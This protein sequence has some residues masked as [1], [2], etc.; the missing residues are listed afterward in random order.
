MYVLIVNIM[1]ASGHAIKT[2]VASESATIGVFCVCVRVACRRVPPVLWWNVFD[3]QYAPEWCTF[4]VY[5]CC[6][7][8]PARFCGQLMT[9]TTPPTTFHSLNLQC[10]LQCRNNMGVVFNLCTCRLYLLSERVGVHRCYTRWCCRDDVQSSVSMC[11]RCT[12]RRQSH[13]MHEGTPAIMPFQR[14]Y[15]ILSSYSCAVFV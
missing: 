13:A 8:C 7:A 4:C 5:K 9:T 3:Q 15:C 10:A 2:R 12:R 1:T 14:G 6:R 11:T